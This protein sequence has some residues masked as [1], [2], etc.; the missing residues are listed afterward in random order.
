MKLSVITIN[1]NNR[2]GL[3]KTIESVVNQTFKDFEYIIIDGGSTDG[4]VEVIKEYAD[5]IDYWVSEPDKGIYNAMNKGI[6]VAKG[7]YCNFM[8]SGDVFVNNNILLEIEDLLIDVGIVYGRAVY[9]DGRMALERQSDIPD[10]IHFFS[11][12]ISH[13]ASFISAKMLKRYHYDER[14]RIVS[15]WK[16]FVQAFVL[17]QCSYRNVDKIINVQESVGASLCLDL[18]KEERTVVLNELF[19]DYIVKACDKLIYGDTWEEKLYIG[20][21]QSKLSSIMY[22]INVL[23]LRFISLFSRQR[24]WVDDFPFNKNKK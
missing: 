20:I 18:I 8:N 6:D 13:Q 10:L 15:D 9:S 5:R 7:E 14:L 2:D 1:F 12:T 19:P 17:E 21:R 16:F 11:N 23:I 3:R 4:S 22:T 24:N